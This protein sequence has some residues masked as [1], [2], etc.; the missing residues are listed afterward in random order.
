M[1]E[2]LRV[3]LRD[4]DA[5]KQLPDLASIDRMRD[6]MVKMMGPSGAA[7]ATRSK[8]KDMRGGCGQQPLQQAHGA[9]ADGDRR[10]LRAHPRLLCRH[11]EILDS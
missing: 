11:C 7:A 4:L 8:I 3:L 10:Q 5:L 2:E 6:R 1:E 9:A